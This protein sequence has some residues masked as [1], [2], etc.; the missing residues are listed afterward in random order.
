MTTARLHILLRAFV[1]GIFLVTLALAAG[2]QQLCQQPTATPYQNLDAT[3]WRLVSTSDPSPAYQSLSKNTFLIMSF[4]IDFKGSVNK[5]VNNDQFDNPI[6]TFEYNVDPSNNI[7]VI[8][9]TTTDQGAQ[10][11]DAGTVQYNYTLSSELDLTDSTHG[12]T[13]R[14]IPFQGVVQPDSNCTF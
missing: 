6:L 4:T 10:S 1:A 11:G 5:V 9:Y 7:L 2:C 13:Y 12:Y 14:Y 3:T 8:Q